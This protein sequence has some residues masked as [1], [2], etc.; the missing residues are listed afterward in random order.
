MCWYLLQFLLFFYF[1]VGFLIAH[2]VWEQNKTLPLR[3]RLKES[4]KALF[5]FPF[6]C[7]DRLGDE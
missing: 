4:L 2:S 3:V 6:K 7:V 5:L 1:G